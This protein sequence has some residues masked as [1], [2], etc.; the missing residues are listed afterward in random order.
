GAI[1]FAEEAG[2]KPDKSFNLTQYMLE[3]DTDEVPLIEYEYGRNGK[4]FLVAKNKLEASRYLPSMKAHLGDNFDVSIGEFDDFDDFDEEE[5]DDEPYTLIETQYTY[6]HPHYP[7]V[8]NVENQWIVPELCDPK[9][10]I[11]PDDNLIDRILALPHD[12]L[13]RDLENLI[14]YYIGLTCDHVP[15]EDSE[16]FNGVI[17]TSVMLLAE[18]GNEDSSLDVVL[19][20]LRQ[21]PEFYDYHI[22]DSGDDT[23]V[24][25]IYKLGQHK[26]DKLMAFAKEEGLYSLSKSCVLSAVSQIAYYQPKRRDEVIEWF[27]EIIQ[28]ALEKLPNPQF[29]DSDLLGDIINELTE[30]RAKELL[31]EIRALFDTGYVETFFTRNYKEVE[32]DILNPEYTSDNFCLL[33]I[34]ERFHHQ[35]ALLKA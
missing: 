19:E 25:T 28:F 23:C 11:A 17:G 27:R 29:F 3:E 13:R 32:E 2:I 20:V 16:D 33:D 14:L 12:S 30:I 5:D 15:D 24:A 7:Q 26:L 10:A 4:H 18:V 34:H 31:K 1:A 9:N 8:L 22:C 35:K 21:S 6:Q